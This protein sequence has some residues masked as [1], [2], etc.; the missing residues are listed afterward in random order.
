G[1][2]PALRV[3]GLTET[4]RTIQVAINNADDPSLSTDGGHGVIGF[5]HTIGGAVAITPPVPGGTSA[6]PDGAFLIAANRA[7]L[8][9]AV[10]GFLPP[11]SGRAGHVYLA[12]VTALDAEGQATGLG[13][14]RLGRY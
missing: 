7:V 3:A 6:M 2:L 1:A 14:I 13:S 8:D 9:P 11:C 5:E 12:E 4:T 10:P